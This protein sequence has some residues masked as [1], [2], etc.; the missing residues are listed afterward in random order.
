MA[1]G[2]IQGKRGKIQI[3]EPK[4]G[5]KPKTIRRDVTQTMGANKNTR[6]LLKQ[7]GYTD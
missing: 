1:K 6:K 7:M 2:M 5:Y 3:T 4:R